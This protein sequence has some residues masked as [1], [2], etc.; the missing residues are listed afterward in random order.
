MGMLN[1]EVTGCRPF[2]ALK[3]STTKCQHGDMAIDAD[4]GG[5]RCSTFS[6]AGR[7]LRIGAAGDFLAR[8][9]RR[10]TEPVYDA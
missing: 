2:I 10:E 8:R 3:N 6:R 9:Q 5:G 1:A 4:V 7:Q